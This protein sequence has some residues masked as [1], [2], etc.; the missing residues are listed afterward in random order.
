MDASQKPLA[1]LPEEEH[2]PA[3]VRVADATIRDA[4]ALLHAN[5]GLS[6]AGA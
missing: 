2:H 5:G 4:N 3:I 6:L 1:P